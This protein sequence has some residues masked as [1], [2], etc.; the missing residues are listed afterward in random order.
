M[1]LTNKIDNTNS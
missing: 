1:H